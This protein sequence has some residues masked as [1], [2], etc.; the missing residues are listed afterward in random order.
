[1][2]A[3]GASR[4][5][6]DT[7]VH[8]DLAPNSWHSDLPRSGNV[9]KCGSEDQVRPTGLDD[10][11]QHSKPSV[12]LEN[13]VFGEPARA[14]LA[15]E[16]TKCYKV[17]SGVES[18]V[19]PV[20][21][22]RMEFKNG[23]L[24][25]EEIQ[26][27]KETANTADK[28]SKISFT[29]A[30]NSSSRR[31]DLYES[32]LTTT[33]GVD[34]GV[35]KELPATRE[36]PAVPMDKPHHPCNHSHRH[37][38]QGDG[39]DTMRL[40]RLD[41]LRPF[42]RTIH[43]LGSGPV[44][45]YVA[46]SLSRLPN[47]PPVSLILHHPLLLQQWQDEGQAIRLVKDS[48]VDVNCDV[49]IDTSYPAQQGYPVGDSNELAHSE[50]SVIDHLIVTTEGGVTIPA[51]KAIKHRLRT[52]STVCI[53]SDGLGIVEEVNSMLF[54]SPL[55][56]P[57]YVLGSMSHNVQASPDWNFA[58][59]ENSIGKLSLTSLERQKDHSNA[60][61]E[62]PPI[63]IMDNGWSTISN[64]SRYLMRVLTRVPEFDATGY[65]NIDYMGSQLEKLAVNAVIGPLSVVFDCLND[66]LL[67]NYHVTRT[68]RPLI[69]EI[70]KIIRNLPEV[71]RMPKAE[72]NFSV[73][74]LQAIVFSVLTRTGRRHSEML[75]QV[76]K[77]QRTDV[78]HFNGYLIKR[79]LE[80]DI[81]C[82]LNEMLLFSVK[83]KQSIIDRTMQNKIPFAY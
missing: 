20:L 39:E 44:G 74:R 77:G 49:N 47:P 33:Q 16:S 54:P 34:D 11:G 7:D 35:R 6:A 73:D 13:E 58:V 30:D 70:S 50:N 21:D 66:E 45:K 19:G 2:E 14:G 57:N 24:D 48:H 15:T 4:K 1:M 22:V 59:I 37:S 41:K 26:N 3:A 63:S 31:P 78:D 55:I 79:A 53:I 12:D 23:D 40:R 17:Q 61:F 68:M 75:I 56:R 38:V 5:S 32:I 69:A 25:V 46:H 36:R 60:D 18:D 29:G 83:G 51:L 27:P 42:S 9:Q 65:A 10:P 52:F 80:L 28:G 81:P 82:P 72:H 43:V 71:K 8:E 62:G 64:T 67:Y 76:Q